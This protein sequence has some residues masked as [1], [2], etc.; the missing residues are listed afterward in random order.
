MVDSDKIQGPEVSPPEPEDKGSRRIDL[1][2]KDRLEAFADG[3]FAIAITLLVLE[4]GLPEGG[5]NFWHSLAEEWPS[6]LGYLVSFAFIGGLWID[7]VSFT[8]LIKQSD[9]TLF[10]LNLL[11]LLFVAILPFSTELMATQL[12]EAGE[13][14]A[15]A[16]FG[17]NLALAS[18]MITATI[19]YT[20]HDEELTDVVVAKP[21]LRSFS[22][23]RFFSSL[24]YL[25]AAVIAI[26]VP[27]AAV[28]I[29]LGTS[30]F[31]VIKPVV[32]AARKR[33]RAKHA[34]I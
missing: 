28:F 8:R 22:R 21:E 23:E 3:V 11:V 4:I 6:F 33:R 25:I 19:S 17:T 7:H 29:Y 32:Q 2:P 15:V 12:G 16:L 34:N 24:T 14:G 13:R 10:S 27:V 30:I 1:L 9:H 31:F 20:L 26:I 18:I 5:E